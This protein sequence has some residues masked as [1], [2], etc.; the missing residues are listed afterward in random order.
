[1]HILG[2][3]LIVLLKLYVLSGSIKVAIVLHLVTLSG[4]FAFEN[5]CLYWRHT[6]SFSM[7]SLYRFHLLLTYTSLAWYQ[8]L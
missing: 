8:I 7:V 3:V 4:P 2:W 5:D 1:M 6:K